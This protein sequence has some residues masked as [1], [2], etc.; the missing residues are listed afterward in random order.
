MKK[1]KSLAWY[2]KNRLTDS[3]ILRT[4]NS[5]NYQMR[6]DFFQNQ[7]MENVIRSHGSPTEKQIVVTYPL[8]SNINLCNLIRS[9]MRISRAPE[10][11]QYVPLCRYDIPFIS[12][13]VY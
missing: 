13:S 1:I 8:P 12:V 5:L 7:C 2:K 11:I 10:L 9:D 4:V 3:V 6:V